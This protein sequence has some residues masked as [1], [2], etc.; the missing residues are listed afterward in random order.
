VPGDY[1]AGTAHLTATFDSG[2][3]AGTVTTKT[4]ITIGKVKADRPK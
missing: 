1:P 4:A 2:P 3:L